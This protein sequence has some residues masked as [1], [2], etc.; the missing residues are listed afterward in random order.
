M[1]EKQ[2]EGAFLENAVASVL[3]FVHHWDIVV[4]N[5][6]ILKSE[7]NK[8]KFAPVV[9]W[10][11]VDVFARA[12]SDSRRSKNFILAP[13]SP[14]EVLLVQA[15]DVGGAL[16]AL[17]LKDARKAAGQ[18]KDTAAIYSDAHPGMTERIRRVIVCV[19]IDKDAIGELTKTGT[20][21]VCDLDRLERDIRRS[22]RKQKRVELATSRTRLVKQGFLADIRD[23]VVCPLIRLVRGYLKRGSSPHFPSMALQSAR[24]LVALSK[25]SRENAKPPILV[26]E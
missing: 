5:H 13:Q 11:E 7:K 16:G 8:K 4:E 9:Q 6:L 14:G 15:K 20:Q 19:G 3:R 24:L 23:E 25:S 12:G 18:L 1:S 2:A 10:K 17:S 26:D 21:V 22:Q